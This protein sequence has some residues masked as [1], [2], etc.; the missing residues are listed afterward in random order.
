MMYKSILRRIIYLSV[1]ILIAFLPGHTLAQQITLDTI[2]L[3]IPEAEKMFLQ[4]NLPLLAAKYNVDANKALI[5]QA[6]LWDNPI[7]QTDQN[8]Y[9]GKFFRHKIE[10]GQ[11]YGQ[12]FIQVQQ[13]IRTAGK[14]NKLA[15]LATD[16]S[17]LAQEQFNDILR[18][19][20]FT[21]QSDFLET[22]HLQKIKKVYDAEITEVERL[23]K[24]MDEVYKLGD[25]SLKENMRL[26]ALLFN[27][28]NELVNIH[29]QLIPLQNEI[30]LIL[31]STESAFIQPVL[32]YHLPDLIVAEL[33]KIDSLVSIAK[34]NRPDIQISKTQLNFQQDNLIYQKALAKPD[35]TLAPEYDRLNSYQTNYVGLTVSVPINVFNKNQGNIKSAQFSIKQQ[36]V[37]LQ[38]QTDKIK[39]E[40]TTALEKAKYYQSINNSNQLSFSENY[41]QLFVNVLKSYQARQISLL[42]FTDFLESYKDTKLKLVEQHNGLVKALA[43]LNYTINKNITSF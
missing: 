18:G 39:N 33:P 4:N 40:V 34:N 17:T 1:I 37:Q 12:I 29:T 20:R 16:N 5:Q 38:F 7:L 26:K 8:V 6:K 30:K 3:S 9:D 35:V 42:D 28:Q 43:D 31:Q 22:A 24:A 41:Q 2:T 32:T 21:L 11:Q 15:Q 10:N 19:L 23:V 25:I 13:L 36:Q 27:L 14:R